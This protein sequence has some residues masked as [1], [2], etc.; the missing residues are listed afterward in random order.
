VNTLLDGPESKTRIA[1]VSFS[2][3]V[4]TY[5]GGFIG[6]SGKQ[7]LINAIDNLSA[8]GALTPRQGLGPPGTFWPRAQRTG[9]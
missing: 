9:K 8:S 3:S 4:T 7:S 2:S 5:A 1:V 6:Y